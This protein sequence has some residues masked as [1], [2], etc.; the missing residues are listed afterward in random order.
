MSNVG[1]RA[2]NF[3]LTDFHSGSGNTEG[4]GGGFN[5]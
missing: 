1:Y 2:G 3:T 4:G 5:G